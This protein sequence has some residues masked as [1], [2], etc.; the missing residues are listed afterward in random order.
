[1]IIEILYPRLCC[2]YGDKGNTMFLKQCFP[3]AEFIFTELNDK[4]YFL[5]N[6]VDLCC[7]YSMSEQNQE[8]ALSRLL[9]YKD[10]FTKSETLFLFLG[11]SMELLGNYIE[12]EDGTRIDGLG[13]FDIHSVRHAPKRFNTLIQ[14][15]FKDITL[16]GYTSRFSDTFGITE[17][18]AFCKTEIGCGSDPQSKLEGIF[19]NNILATY[20]LGPLLPANPDFT[21]W[22]M[23]KLG[24]EQPVL[25]YEDALYIAY[26]TKRKE[27][28]LPDLELE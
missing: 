10:S 2:L 20:L 18:I 5:E 4:P 1:M 9:P 14:A 23:Q 26:E 21:K 28:Q 27:F 12:A 22:L 7:M 15:Q 16:L 6:K 13:L 17:D 19:V 25:P 24:C 8:R 11:N 3:E